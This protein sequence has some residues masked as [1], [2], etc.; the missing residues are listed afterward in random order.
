MSDPL[1]S[2]ELPITLT[3]NNDGR[4]KA[5]FKSDKERKD[6]EQLLRLSGHVRK[7]FDQ[8]VRVTVTRVLGARQRLWDFSSG[9]RGNYKELED[10]MVACGW[11]HDDGPT[12]VCGVDFRQDSSRRANGPA[13]LVEVFGA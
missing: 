7:P 1:L 11:F 10:A 6:F 13:V 5:W 4:S 2:V 3:N 12:W 8:P 9:L